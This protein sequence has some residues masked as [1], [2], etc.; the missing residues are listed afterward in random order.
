MISLKEENEVMWP[1]ETGIENS[2]TSSYLQVL[3]VD[4]G[5][6]GGVLARTEVAN[7]DSSAGLAAPDLPGTQVFPVIVSG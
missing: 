2:R 5:K 7:A 1:A 3:I 6:E 4:R